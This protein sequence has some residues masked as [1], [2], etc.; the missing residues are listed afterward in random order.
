[1]GSPCRRTL[2]PSR[3]V[4]DGKVPGDCHAFL[5]D[6]AEA[7]LAIVEHQ[8]Y[9]RTPPSPAT[10]PWKSRAHPDRGSPGPAP[11]VACQPRI[12]LD[13]ARRPIKSAIYFVNRFYGDINA[14]L[15][16]L[17]IVGFRVPGLTTT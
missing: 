11:V 5:P 3:R 6:L 14:F 2:N 12:G 8:A 16:L 7:V 4:T 15:M 10:R 1:M 9:R 17:A 13:L